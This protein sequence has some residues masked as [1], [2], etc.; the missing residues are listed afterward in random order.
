LGRTRRVSAE[1]ALA[2]GWR[3]RPLAQ[4]VADS[5]RSLVALG[6]VPA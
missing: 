5:A 2:L 6:V 1:P 3:P 4:T